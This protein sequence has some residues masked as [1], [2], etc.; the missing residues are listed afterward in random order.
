MTFSVLLRTSKLPLQWTNPPA[1][2]PDACPLVRWC[3]RWWTSLRSSGCRSASHS[4]TPGHCCT[5]TTAP[6]NANPLVQAFNC[7]SVNIKTWNFL[8]SNNFIVENYQKLFWIVLFR[9]F[10][11]T[12]IFF[13]SSIWNLMHGRI[14]KTPPSHSC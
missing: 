3:T 10:N 13:L 7:I 1:H 4:T 12:P 5:N 2:C 6:C 14:W 9:H 11:M 8:G